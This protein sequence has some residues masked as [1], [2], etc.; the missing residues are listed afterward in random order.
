MEIDKTD[1][2]YTYDRL[3]NF[4]KNY[5]AYINNNT[6]NVDGKTVDKFVYYHFDISPN[7]IQSTSIGRLPSDA[8][9]SIFSW[10]PF[11][12]TN[13]TNAWLL[14]L[15]KTN[16]R[17]L[18]SENERI[19]QLSVQP[20]LAFNTIGMNPTN[21]SF[22]FSTFE[23][24]M[25]SIFNQFDT[26]SNTVTSLKSGVATSFDTLQDAF[27]ISDMAELDTLYSNALS[28]QNTFIGCEWKGF[29]KPPQM[30][31]YRITVNS[32]DKL[33]FV[34]IG[35]V[36]V[37]EYTP[38]N[39]N[40]NDGNPYVD[41]NVVNDSYI[42]IRIQYYN[43]IS[44][45]SITKSINFS[46]K[47][48]HML[49]NTI[50]QIPTNQCFYTIDA[51]NYIKPILYCAFVSTSPETYAQGKLQCYSLLRSI[52]DTSIATSDLIQLYT[53]IK[54]YKQQVY[55]NTYDYSPDGTIINFGQLPNNIFYTPV[56]D[57]PS[58]LPL[59]FSIYRID[60]DL[61]MGHTYQINTKINNG[62]YDMRMIDPNANPSVIQYGS[63][64]HEYSD[65]YPEVG[66]SGM[67]SGSTNQ[68]GEQCKESCTALDNCNHYYVYTSQGKE[69]C[70][71]D[72]LNSMPTYNQIRP[73]TSNIDQGSAALF[74]RNYQFVEP[75][76]SKIPGMSD[77]DEIIRIKTVDA[78][79]NYS[80][81]FPFA[82]YNI[83]PDQIKTVKDIGICGDNKFKH[84]TNDAASILYK[85]ATYYADGSWSPNKEGF[86]QQDS[87]YTD[88]ID[89]TQNAIQVNLAHEQNY[90]IKMGNINKNYNSL[91][92]DKLPKY[93]K[94]KQVLED[95]PIYDYN[96]HEL[97]YFNN[98]PP[99]TIEQQVIDDN[100][101]LYVKDYLMYI[102]GLITV[103][104]LLVF[105]IMI[106]RE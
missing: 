82:N 44:A 30:G 106:A 50:Q 37:C 54:K 1:S 95:N 24:N 28:S 41:M 61:R 83:L 42:P 53:T 18:Q 96:G 40:I 98:I 19:K 75:T 76:C 47:I 6:N 88:A 32:S 15:G 34:W 14:N 58:S 59:V 5:K 3:S 48:E 64:Y 49:N 97:S 80:A 11:V 100:N 86:E 79:D 92:N 60:S 74:I 43:N 33:Y 17:I 10:K 72:T 2:L 23:T 78:T 20:G 99:N 21:Y 87:K 29:F 71:V 38:Y 52:R 13:T 81:S 55:Q 56:Q 104:I 84:L 27:Q 35:N 67:V 73:A 105:A 62:S 25:F 85:D 66:A 89:D 26:T 93:K 77:K 103:V 69:Q 9:T 102:L 57:S 45:N 12:N 63:T 65:Y 31:N 70:V 39:T 51:G 68:T 4:V 22:D 16:T 36:S 90:A 8:F 46:L 101:E 94:S 7:G 91:T